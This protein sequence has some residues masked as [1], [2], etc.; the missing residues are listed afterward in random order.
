MKTI[1]DATN[2]DELLDI[3][4]GNREHRNVMNLRQKQKL[5]LLVKWLKKKEKKLISPRKNLLKKRGLRKVIFP[6]LRMEK[7]TF[8]FQRYLKYLRKVWEKIRINNK[9]KW[10]KTKLR[11]HNIVQI[12]GRRLVV[13]GWRV[14][15]QFHLSFGQEIAR[16]PPQKLA[17]DR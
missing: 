1:K 13:C 11:R 17:P 4:Y 16:N 14:H 9:L 8:K 10:T 7:L 15:A 6:A 5:L 12:S 3:K 2:F